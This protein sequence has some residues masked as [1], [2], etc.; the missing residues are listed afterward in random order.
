LNFLKTLGGVAQEF[1]PGGIIFFLLL[2][3]LQRRQMKLRK[4]WPWAVGFL[5]LPIAYS[6][7]AFGDSLRVSEGLPLATVG[8]A[9]WI[10]RCQQDQ[11]KITRLLLCST[12][13]FGLTT[14][15]GRVVALREG[16]QARAAL[17]ETVQDL[18]QREGPLLLLVEDEEP[19]SDSFR[20]EKG[21]ELLSWFNAIP[22]S[23]ILV[24]RNLPDLQPRLFKRYP[25]HTPV[26][27]RIPTASSSGFPGV[28]D[29]ELISR[30]V[31]DH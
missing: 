14:D 31:A 23:D 26:R 13:L 29:I 17:F 8:T 15:I 4:A 25:Q 28:P 21:L 5:A 3:T 7:Y 10:E 9:L 16:H 24:G 11:P 1:W 6:F 20:T 19:G 18:R 2:V 27:L 12:L 22:G 30:E